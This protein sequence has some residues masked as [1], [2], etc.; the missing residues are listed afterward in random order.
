M[1]TL[2]E[3]VSQVDQ[4][5]GRK[6]KIAAVLLVIAPVQFWILE[7]ISASAWVSPRYS[8][9]SNAISDL[10]VNR[11]VVLNGRHLNSPL[12]LLTAFSFGALG[13][14]VAVAF[15]LIA[16]TIQRSHRQRALAV[17]GVIF[18]I[19]SLIVALV[20]ENTVF[21][22]HLF[23]A[24]LNFWDGFALVIIAGS[25]AKALGL[26]RPVAIILIVLGIFG[27]VCNLIL[28]GVDGF[29]SGPVVKSFGSGAVERTSGYSYLVAMG[30]LGI[31]ILAQKRASG[32]PA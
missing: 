24:L 27:F 16:S 29:A 22:G 14:L 21:I 2:L 23:G 15:L 28:F 1:S 31:A 5:K 26:S 32:R 4:T 12:H 17:L 25:A 10:G 8:Y 30:I 18:G 11:D 7:A 20:P 3:S 13:V 9:F 19:G 6:R